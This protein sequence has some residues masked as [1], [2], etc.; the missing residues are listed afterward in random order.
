MAVTDDVSHILDP[1]NDAQRD[2]VAGAVGNT[3]VLA[4]AGS[5]KTRVLVHR[6]A[7][8]VQAE[9]VSPWSILAVTFTNKAAAEMKQRSERLLDMPVD[10]LWIGTFHGIA[11]RL[12]RAHWQEAGLPQGFQILD[13]DDQQRLVKRIMK[14]LQ[15]DDSRWPPRQAAW[16]INQQKDEGR[17][18]QHFDPGHDPWAVTMQRVYEAYEEAC[19]RGGLV[20][21]AELLLRAHELLRDNTEL[22]EHYRRRFKHLL[23]DEF[24]DT[25]T[26]QYAWLRLLAG[27]Q[28]QVFVVGDDDQCLVEDTK[29]QLSNGKEKLIQDIRAGD[30]VLSS[31]GSGDMRAANVLRTSKKEASDLVRIT[32]TSGQTITST[33]EH[34]HFASYVD[35]ARTEL[36]NEPQNFLYL[37]EKIGI[38]FRIGITSTHNSNRVKSK[39]GFMTRS[40]QEHADKLWIIDT[41]SNEQ[42]ARIAEITTSLNYKIPTLPFTPRR[43]RKTQNGLVHDLEAIKAIFSQIDSRTGALQLLHDAGLDPEQPHHRPQSRNS[44]RINV[45]ITLCGDRRGKTPMH[46]ISVIGNNQNHAEALRKHGFSIRNARSTSDSWRFE[47]SN[48]DFEKIIESAKHIQHLLDA[49]IILNA[50]LGKFTLSFIQA[51]A[52]RRG[53]QIYNENGELLTVNKVE[54]I[55]KRMTVY[56]IDIEN[57]HNFIANGILTHNSVYGW[58]GAKVE[59]VRQF[60]R[61]FAPMRTVRLEQNY[62]STGNI[63]KAANAVI[64]NN[65]DRLGKTLWTEAS[66]GE[67]IDVYAAYNDLDEAR[68]VVNA[69]EGAVLNG[70]RRSEC[71]V[72]YRSNAQSRVLEE[73]LIAAGMPYRVYGGLRF[74]E[75][76][77]IKDALAYL[78]L[79]ENERDDAAFERI[80][81]VPTRGIGAQTVDVIRQQARGSN[82]SMHEAARLLVE[83]EGLP[84]RAR[85]AVAAFLDKM[86]QLR[87]AMADEQLQTQVQT[88]IELS[89]LKDHFAKE[90]GEKGQARIENLDELVNAAREFAMQFEQAEEMTPLA[91]F[92]AQ[93]ALEAGTEQASEWEDAVQLMTLHSAKGLEF[94][95]VFLCG[96]E[97]GLFPH[98]MSAE[99]P[100]RL[101]EER[102]L[103]YVGITRA[104]EHLTLSYAEVRRLYGQ[105]SYQRPSR[106][107]QEIP[108]ELLNEVRGAQTTLRPMRS[109]PVHGMSHREMHQAAAAQH[110]LNLGQRVA[111]PKFGEGT[112]LDLEGDG[113]SARVQVKFRE[114]GS[115][116]LVLAYANLQPA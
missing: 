11:H 62:R 75:R 76:A 100:G 110:G 17:R 104:R 10:H 67:R 35:P 73:A 97:E 26:L 54:K 57:T 89:G 71:A 24:Q 77:E 28:G 42:E 2:A 111:H 14:D 51:S 92:L 61:D 4:G 59:N 49:S 116:W 108:S 43:N 3:L 12:L 80:V 103:C 15:L 37:M 90:R 52:V 7:W 33:P 38:G 48:K 115:K 66:D 32:T 46:R 53:M 6:L 30:Q 95:R 27:E 39:L 16:F 98:S 106:F 63:L 50:R 109:T 23:V 70:Q 74:F 82:Q 94:P 8:L 34:T 44:N 56:D 93:A 102:R 78:R 21:F 5:G 113:K 107:L 58:R 85:N 87:T 99:E 9:G 47:T 86:Q 65:P 29:I 40:V 18:P 91:G 41:F 83:S 88:A 31:Y 13:S 1:L 69:I 36:A 81:N 22:L 68:Y 45:N 20:D 105:E 96:M 114:H 64:E 19:Q 72:L 55:K 79:A 84:G 101:E 25:N 60:A 112:I